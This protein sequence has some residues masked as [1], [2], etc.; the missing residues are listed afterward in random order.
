HQKVMMWV[1]ISGTAIS[2]FLV[3]VMFMVDNLKTVEL[4]PE[5]DRT[6]IYEGLNMHIRSLEDPEKESGGYLTY[7]A[8]QRLY[9]NLDGVEQVAYCY[10]MVIPQNI[11][12]KG[13]IPLKVSTFI[14]DGNYWNM[15][16][17]NFVSGRPFTEEECLD[18]T[19][20][21]VLSQRIAQKLFSSTDVVGREVN[22]GGVNHIVSGVVED[23]NPI[24]KNSWSD[25]Y[26]T[27]DSNSRNRIMGRSNQ[28]VMGSLKVLLKYEKNTDPEYVKQQ[29]K[30]R[31][32]ALNSELAKQDWEIVYHGTPY[33]IEERAKFKTFTDPDVKSHQRRRSLL[34]LVLILLPAINLSSMVRG[35]LQRRVSEIGVRRAYGATRRSILLQLLGENLIVTLAGGVVGFVFTFLFMLFMS[36]EF[37]ILAESDFFFNV[38]MA[39]PTFD[40][41]FMWS[42]FIFALGICFVLN[43]LTAT[44]PAWKAASVE[45]AVA[46]SK[47]KN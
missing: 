38:A 16:D 8:A 47:S 36:S 30:S 34:Y 10:S 18:A 1:S 37:F 32:N 23:T 12:I 11:M 35:R 31:Y 4:A 6:R 21:I 26:V 24:L 28:T 25:V 20:R 15:Y 39:T 41:L 43:L 19:N 5:T 14:V 45:P 33:S 44:I 3:M 27:L 46:I 40:M 29:V 17:F 22:I 2:I 7:D 9:G 42:P 13:G